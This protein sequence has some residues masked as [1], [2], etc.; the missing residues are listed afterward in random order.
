[1]LQYEH[2]QP[3]HRR[4]AVQTST[5]AVLDRYPNAKVPLGFEA[6]FNHRHE[7]I[8]IVNNFMLS[9]ARAKRRARK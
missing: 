2:D 3:V 8:D 4:R 9:R 1:M 5:D 6:L 7:P